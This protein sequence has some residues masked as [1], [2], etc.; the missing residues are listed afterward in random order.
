MTIEPGPALA[1]VH[2]PPKT[3]PVKRYWRWE[4]IDPDWRGSGNLWLRSA[5]D[6]EAQCL[7][8]LEIAAGLRP[9]GVDGAEHRRDIEGD[10][11]TVA[12][13]VHAAH[14]VVLGDK[15]RRHDIVRP[16]LDYQMTATAAAGAQWKI[17]KIGDDAVTRAAPR[18][19]GD[20]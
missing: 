12:T 15:F 1:L 17:R 13:L 20:L 2:R 8:A 9:V 18:A 16:Q 10:A 4:W 19:L 7:A 6:T 5:E 3:E 11:R 14:A